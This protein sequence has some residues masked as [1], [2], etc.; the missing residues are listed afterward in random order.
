MNLTLN[1]LVNSGKKI[2][3]LVDVPELYFDSRE[4]TV[5][6]PIILPGHEPRSP[7]AIDRKAFDERSADYHRIVSDLKSE[8]PTVKFIDTYEYLCDSKYCYGSLDGELLYT[9]HHHLT[10]AG[11]RYLVRKLAGQLPK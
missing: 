11:S 8:F 1:R 9:G 3:Y 2:F 10:T 5:F 7:C 6:R 4:C